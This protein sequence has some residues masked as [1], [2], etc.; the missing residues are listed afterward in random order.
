[1]PLY[2]DQT[3]RPVSIKLQPSR[4]ISLVPS[5]TE[6]L[7]DLGLNEEVVGITRFCIRPA[8]WFHTKRRVGGTKQLHLDLIGELQPDLIIANKEENEKTQ[9]EVLAKKFP[10]WISNINNLKDACKMI[11]EIGII[12][13]TT[14]KAST[15]VEQVRKNFSSLLMEGPAP[16]AAY[17][18]WRN[19][20]MVAGGNTFINAMMEAAGFENIFKDE[21]RYP[22]I[23]LE[24]LKIKNP[25]L[26]LLSSEPYPFQQKHLDELQLLLPHARIILVDGEMFSWYGSRLLQSPSYFAGLQRRLHAVK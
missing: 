15:L 4:I 6:L 8:E 12:T 25:E 14:K 21:S 10:V 5:Q 23:H 3:G 1:M 11:S 17:F 20:Y 24:E 2:I 9:I 19:P 22:E 18:I 13:D 26:I 7:H 16:T